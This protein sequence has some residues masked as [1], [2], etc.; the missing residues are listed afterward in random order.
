MTGLL[1]QLAKGKIKRLETKKPK[2]Q[3][4]QKEKKKRV[5]HSIVKKATP[6]VEHRGNADE[7]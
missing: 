5:P 1:I 6:R 4:S 7:S 3:E 2:G